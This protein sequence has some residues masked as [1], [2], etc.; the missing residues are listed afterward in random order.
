MSNMVLVTERYSLLLEK[1]LRGILDNFIEDK[2]Y[3]A[4]KTF[5]PLAA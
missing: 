4:E 1:N 3:I 2:D 5:L